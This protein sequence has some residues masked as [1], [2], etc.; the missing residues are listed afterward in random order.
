MDV[1]HRDIR[2]LD[3]QFA[4]VLDLDQLAELVAADEAHAADGECTLHTG[5]VPVLR[6]Q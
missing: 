4:P 3:A 1:L 6:R 2:E 5:C